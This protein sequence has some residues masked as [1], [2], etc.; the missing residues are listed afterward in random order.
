MSSIATHAKVQMTTRGSDGNGDNDRA[1]LY[2]RAL[3]VRYCPWDAMSRG[4]CSNGPDPTRRGERYL[5]QFVH[6]GC[7]S[8]LARKLDQA[9]A[10]A[11]KQ[12]KFSSLRARA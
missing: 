6:D 10:V 3:C 7:M 1:F 12:G 8:L 11:E 4:T 5:Q 2:F 9:I